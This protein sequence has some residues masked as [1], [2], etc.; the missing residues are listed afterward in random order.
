MFV[1]FKLTPLCPITDGLGLKEGL[2]KNF[3]FWLPP[4]GPLLEGE[5]EV[6]GIEAR[7]GSGFGVVI[8]R[9]AGALD[10]K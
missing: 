2:T 10:F 6:P 5:D 4:L 8:T 1:P 7:A 3:G 9:G